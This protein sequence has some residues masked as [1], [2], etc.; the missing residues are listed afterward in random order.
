MKQ[1]WKTGAERRQDG[2]QTVAF[3]DGL[4]WGSIGQVLGY[5]L[6][7]VDEKQKDELYDLMLK[8]YEGSDRGKVI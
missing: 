6:G 3:E 1:S 2:S 5:L 4:T 7:D 8:A